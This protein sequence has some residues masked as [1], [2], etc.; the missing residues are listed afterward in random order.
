MFALIAAISTA[1]TDTLLKWRFSDLGPVEMA[2][3]RFLSPIPLLLP[4]LFITR[5]PCLGP[6]F[7]Q[8]VL[9]LVP[10]EYLA[11]ITYMKALRSS[12][13]SLSI[14]MLAFSPSLIILTGWLI[15]GETVSLRG[16]SGIMS[17]VFGAYLLHLK[18]KKGAKQDILAPFRSLFTHTGSR[19]MFVVA[20]IYSITSCLGKKAILYSSPTFFAPFYFSLVGSTFAAVFSISTRGAVIGNIVQHVKRSHGKA[21]EVWTIISIGLLQTAMVYSHMMAISLTSAAYMITVKRTSLLFSILMGGLFF[22]ERPIWPRFAGGVFMILG[23]FLV[24]TS[25]GGGP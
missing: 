9:V 2:L 1:L 21:L 25:R 15:L 8:V 6:G 19:Y 16:F 4:L 14:P 22:S 5:V 10:L 12:E 18:V 20:A 23:V 3:M 11:M 24:M 13:M 17:T 7:W